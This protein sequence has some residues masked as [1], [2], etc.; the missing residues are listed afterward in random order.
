[1]SRKGG[2]PGGFPGGN[3]NAMLKQAQK[4]QKEMEKA[5]QE[6]SQKEVEASVG[7]G[8]VVVRAN[9]AKEILSIKINPDVLDPQDPETAED[10]ILTAVNQ[11]LKSAEDMMNS[12]MGKITGSMG[13]P[14]LF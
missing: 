14:G 3:M 2:F 6:A 10:L 11:A 9:G 12:T 13:I 7:G 4:M 8:A 1:M 5:Q